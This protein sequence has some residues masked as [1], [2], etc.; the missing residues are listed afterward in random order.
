MCMVLRGTFGSLRFGNAASMIS[1]PCLC[2]AS[3]P[4]S[5]SEL[6]RANGK[7]CS[8]LNPYMYVIIRHAHA[9]MNCH[10][11]H[12]HIENSRFFMPCGAAELR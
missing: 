10:A 5:V 11:A 6:L 2:V 12:E 8:L 7:D 9:C 4:T 1:L 3:L